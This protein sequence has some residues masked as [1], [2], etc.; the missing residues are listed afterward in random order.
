MRTGL[1]RPL[2]VGALGLS[3]RGIGAAV[4]VASLAGCLGRSVVGKRNRD[5]PELEA[6]QPR[7]CP[8]MRLGC[9]GFAEPRRPAPLEDA[10]AVTDAELDA[11]ANASCDADGE[12]VVCVGSTS[13][14]SPNCTRACAALLAADDL[15]SVVSAGCVA[16]NPITVATRW[17]LDDVTLSCSRLDIVLA[18]GA[19]LEI[20]DSRLVG[21]ELHIQGGPGSTVRM[22]RVEGRG[23]RIA[24]DGS[25][26]L[27]ID[28]ARF[29]DVAI[30][31]AEGVQGQAVRMS[32]TALVAVTIRSRSRAQILLAGVRAWSSLLDVADAIIEDAELIDAHVR[33][34]LAL[35][36]GGTITGGQL[37]LHSATLFGTTVVEAEVFGCSSM[38]MLQSR[39]RASYLDGCEH[40]IDIEA[41]FVED[42]TLIRGAVRG[43]NAVIRESGFSPGMTPAVV[44]L[45]G[46]DVSNSIFCGAEYLQ[47]RGGSLICVTCDPDIQD[48]SLDG[49]VVQMSD[50]PVIEEAVRDR[51]GDRRA[52]VPDSG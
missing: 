18:A 30:E 50:C 20:D 16:A 23:T 6:G 32:D 41:S 51:D 2:A 13:S 35:I 4:I 11:A 5:R 40:G 3:A 31:V 8:A 26:W 19:R 1:Q 47:T 14:A 49:T 7:G 15:S 10:L 52:V 38:Q 28:Q 25:A 45:V 37:E 48:V 22:R 24:L 27:E 36:V 42:G 21:V 29:D 46:G 34:T 33:A 17:R 43:R 12:G 44:A 39:V 9:D